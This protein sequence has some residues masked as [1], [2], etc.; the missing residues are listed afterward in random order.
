MDLFL[1]LRHVLI[2][3]HLRTRV[4]FCPLPV[5]CS[6]STYIWVLLDI[7]LDYR[8]RKMVEWDLKRF[9]GWLRVLLVPQEK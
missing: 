4:S 5:C 8:R 9:Q 7:Y 3:G 6:R 1:S 2:I